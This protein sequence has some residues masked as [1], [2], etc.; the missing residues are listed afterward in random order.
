MGFIN[1]KKYDGIQLY[2]KKNKDITYYI[3]YKNEYGKSVRIKV[4]EKSKGITEPYCKQKRDELLNKL[5]LG[6]DLPIRQKKRS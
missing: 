4:G 5:R 3:R 6:E 1:S 2:Y